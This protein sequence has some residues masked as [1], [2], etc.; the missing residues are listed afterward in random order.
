MVAVP[1]ERAIPDPRAVSIVSFLKLHH[2]M[3]T[4]LSET[5]NSSRCQVHTTTAIKATVS[6][7]P[8]GPSMLFTARSRRAATIHMMPDPGT[9]RRG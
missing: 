9:V 3:T 1:H 4:G 5:A 7:S 2:P 6:M 8:K